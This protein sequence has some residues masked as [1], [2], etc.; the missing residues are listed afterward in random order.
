MREAKLGEEE[1]KDYARWLLLGE[2]AFI[3]A[4]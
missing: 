3:F 2:R 1:A 4:G